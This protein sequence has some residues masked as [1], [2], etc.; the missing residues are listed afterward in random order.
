VL[1]G[2]RALVV[3]DD[4]DAVD[5]FATA[6][7]ACGADVVTATSAVAALRVVAGRALDIVVTDIAMPGADGYW[8]VGEI[9]Q[10]PDAQARTLPVLAV[11]AFGREHFRSRALAAGFVDYLEKPVDPEALCRTVARVRRR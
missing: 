5:L 9:R 3:D 6:L 4:E 11:T 2:V 10:L 7:A 8:L 1:Q